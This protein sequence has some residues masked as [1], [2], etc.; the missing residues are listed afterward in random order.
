MRVYQAARIRREQARQASCGGAP[1]AARIRC[2]RQKTGSAWRAGEH[3]GEVANARGK[4]D[5]ATRASSIGRQRLPPRIARIM[6]KRRAKHT[7]ALSASTRILQTP[8]LLR[9]LWKISCAV[10]KSSCEGRRRGASAKSIK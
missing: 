2:G 6:R 8:H 1:A 7:Y 9:A 4:H 3:R 10:L 5:G